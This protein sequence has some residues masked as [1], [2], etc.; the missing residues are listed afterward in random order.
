MRLLDI[1][2]AGTT[3]Y[4]ATI[5]IIDSTDGSAEQGVEHDT[6]GVALWYRREG[7]AKVAIS[8]AALASLTAGH[9]D[10]GIEHIDDGAY[11]LDLEDD[12][13]AEGA[14]YVDI[15]GTITG[16][17]VIGGRIR[18]TAL[19]LDDAE[20]ETPDDDE[21][22][23]DIGVRE[24]DSTFYLNFLELNGDGPVNPSS[25]AITMFKNGSTTA[26]PDTDG[27]SG[28]IG[29]AS[30]TGLVQISIDSSNDS[31]KAGWWA[32]G[33]SYL[34]EAIS[35]IPSSVYDGADITKRRYW[36][37]TLGDANGVGDV[38]DM[39]QK[40]TIDT[41]ASQTSFTLTEGSPDDDAYNGAMLIPVDQTTGEQK[42]VVQI[43]DYVGLTK[44]ITLEAAPEFTIAD[45][46]IIKIIASPQQLDTIEAAVETDHAE[47][48]F[49]WNLSSETGDVLE[50]AAWLDL[51]GQT[52]DIDTLHAAATCSIKIRE[53]SA[54]T[55]APLL[56]FNLTANVANEYEDKRF[57]FEYTNPAPGSPILDARAEYDIEVI[58]T[59]NS[60]T[61]ERNFSR[62]TF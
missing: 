38:P 58:I 22:V 13:V 5:S 25:V 14:S 8:P 19:D 60:T 24:V 46:D 23:Q 56:T 6:S 36:R 16:M 55:G 47:C 54:A 41:L 44:T 43:T 53:F 51:N 28:A 35:T 49:D 12:A 32:K 2:Q 40:T 15:G 48:Q 52:A 33:A 1:I 61:Y 29:F 4:S 26:I 59:I 3:N 45:G 20:S 42:D 27:I 34:V 9:S 17:I 39:L 57:Q 50:V 18:L 21:T 62:K 31:G 7:G 10:G 11:R 30:K 37:F